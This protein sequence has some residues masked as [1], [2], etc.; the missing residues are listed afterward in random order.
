MLKRKQRILNITLD[1]M[2][3]AIIILMAYTP[4]GFLP[5]GMISVTIIHI[6]VLLGACLFGKKKGALYGLFFGLV[7]MF[8][9]LQSPVSILDPYF[10]NPIVSVLPRVLF[11]FIAGLLFDLVRKFVKNQGLKQG[12]FFLSGGIATL[13][14]SVMVLSI[15]GFV[16]SKQLN[17]DLSSYYASYW[18]FMG[19]TLTSSSL[20]EALAGAVLTPLVALPLEK[21]VL[22]N[23]LVSYRNVEKKNKE[24]IYP[25]GTICVNDDSCDIDIIVKK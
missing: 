25:R 2:F 9:A 4:I 7:S 18:I 21:Y 14:H 13:L 20:L 8:K 24:N 5:L 19:A 17:I 12:L 15:L 6:P 1:A 3:L 23:Y 16:Y 11:G 22:K 10:Q